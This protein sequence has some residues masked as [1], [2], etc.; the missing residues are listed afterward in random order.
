MAAAMTALAITVLV[1]WLPW[2][3]APARFTPGP[4]L[5]GESIETQIAWLPDPDG[6]LDVAQ[7]LAAGDRFR[8]APPPGQPPPGEPPVAAG[9]FKR[10]PPPPE[11]WESRIVWYKVKLKELAPQGG[12]ML[13]MGNAMAGAFTL[14]VSDGEGAVRQQTGEGRFVS[15]L[16]P[17]PVPYEFLVR[18]SESGPFHFRPR[19]IPV[20]A[21]TS[22]RG[23][24]G[25][26][27]GMFYGGLMVIAMVN[28]LFGLL[29]GEPGH[30][31]Y[32]AS[33]AFL[34]GAFFLGF[35]DVAGVSLTAGMDVL[36]PSRILVAAWLFCGL[37]LI[38]SFL[39]T[40][41]R[42]PRLDKLLLLLMYALPLLIPVAFAGLGPPLRHVYLA[43]TL[44]V[45]ALALVTGTIAL[46]QGF[47]P[48]RLFL[49]AWL[50]VLAF[51][52]LPL[53]SAIFNR[54]PVLSP[55]RAL[56]LTVFLQAAVFTASLLDKVR[57][58]LAENIH[59]LERRRADGRIVDMQRRLFG[60]VAH[61]L[62]KPLTRLGLAVELSEGSGPT[63]DLSGRM[64]RD[65]A[66]LAGLRDQMLDLARLDGRQ[67]KLR[68]LVDLTG[69][70]RQASAEAADAPGA[71]MVRTAGPEPLNVRGD[72]ML[73]KRALDNL[74]GN[75]LA[76]AGPPVTVRVETAGSEAVLTVRDTGPGVPPAEVERIFEPFVRLEARPDAPKGSGL[77]LAIV[78]RVAELHGGRAVA[79]NLAPGFEVRLELPL[80]R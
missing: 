4:N 15:F 70:A 54:P 55:G 32:A 45:T 12:L 59:L 18:A 23:T 51:P 49:A 35:D 30:A 34:G 71:V 60:E 57:A 28:I 47:S 62:T 38:R 10:P 48:A 29:L 64:H 44:L 7:A 8:P 65:L 72:A 66:A 17:D 2:T 50:L 36:T 46:R 24:K 22:E 6:S 80:A 37:G 56:S 41:R 14:A 73:L 27:L 25:L 1:C 43:L 67:H 16:L 3:G 11:P 42:T 58:M 52:L 68:E 39:Q 74:I 5:D 79:R 76:Y 31:W 26:A 77:G 75:A 13:E 78:H 20:Q 33:L 19:L 40:A 21:Y 53:V 9:A 69:L 61:E 63:P